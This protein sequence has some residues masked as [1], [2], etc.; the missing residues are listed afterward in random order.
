[1]KFN[2]ILQ[3]LG[4]AANCNSLRN[5]PAV[6]PEITGVAPIDDA[7]NGT[8]SYIEGD[9][10]VPFVATTDASALILPMLPELQTQASARGMAWIAS[11]EP[12]LLFAKVISLLYQP[13]RPKP[14]IDPTAAIDPSAQ[15]GADV[16]IGANVSIAPGVTIGQGVQIYPNV[17]I[18]PQVSIGDR[19]ILHA[20]CTIHE[21]SSIGSN[22]VIHSGAVI[23]AEGFGFV[24]SPTGWI[25]ME[26]SGH[27]ILEDGVEVGCNSTIDRPAVGQTR[28]GAN[29]KIDNLVQVG[30]GCQIGKNCALAAHVGL[31]GGVK[32]EDNVI[33]AGQVGVANRVTIG[34]GAIATAKSGI[35]SDVPSGAI[36][37]GYPAIPNKVWLKT[38][39]ISNRLPEI[40]QAF[41]QLKR[42]FSDRT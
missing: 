38:V 37:S 31:A 39:A 27:T 29:T 5:D 20:N 14:G 41:K 9:K 26:Q 16:Y 12:R 15:I 34:S 17:V 19:T 11:E 42:H 6:N 13:W 24:P 18:Y 4:D 10:F 22:C 28:I 3:K 23:G 36:V 7:T 2:E 40:Y 21:R 25:K 32:I 30:H 8:F 1:M 33:L 35:H